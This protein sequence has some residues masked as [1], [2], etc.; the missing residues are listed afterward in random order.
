MGITMV[1]HG[2]D[3]E[4]FNVSHTIVFTLTYKAYNTT[5]IYFPLLTDVRITQ[6]FFVIETCA[7][8]QNYNCYCKHASIGVPEKAV[9]ILVVNME[10]FRNIGGAIIVHQN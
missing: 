5:E 8:M 1:R 3:H 10:I 4:I 2:C 6:E 7:H 9:I